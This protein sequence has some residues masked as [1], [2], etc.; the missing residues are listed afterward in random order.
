M[1]IRTLPAVA[2]ALAFSTPAWA[3]PDDAIVTDRPDF[4]ESSNVVG[5]HRLQIETSVA[6]DRDDSAGVKS[7]S[8]ATPT[9]LRFGVSDDVELRIET[10]GRLRARSDDALN[11]IHLRDSGYADTALG[12]KWHAMDASGAL[13]SVGLLF[14]ADLDSGSSAFRG[15]GVRPSLRMAAEWELPAGLSLGVMPGL[16]VEKDAAGKRYASGIFGVVVGRSLTDKLR[17]FVEFSAPAIARARNGGTVATLDVGVA[18]LLTDQC[19]LDTALSRGLNSR[20]PD[21]SW[22]VGIS[23][24]L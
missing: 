16:A 8:R 23:F 10:D 20:T 24:K 1:P 17:G 9:L 12:L 2:V 5:K 14:H 6:F 11:G 7:R 15:N 18:Y 3:E 13:P 21:T 4:V 22:T 19:Q